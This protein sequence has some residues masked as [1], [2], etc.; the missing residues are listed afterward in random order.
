MLHR[1]RRERRW[2]RGID[3]GPGWRVTRAIRRRVQ[4][5]GQAARVA[6]AATTADRRE[7]PVVLLWVRIR[8]RR[9]HHLA[10]GR[11]VERIETTMILRGRDRMQGVGR[12]IHATMRQRGIRW[13]RERRK[14]TIVVIAPLASRSSLCHGLIR[15]RSRKA[16]SASAFW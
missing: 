14:S 5:R 10:V 6:R 15:T 4:E 11:I 1:Y 16:T 7:G 9:N 2:V 8:R 3:S 12:S 13:D